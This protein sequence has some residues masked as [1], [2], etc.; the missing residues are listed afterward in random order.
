MSRPHEDYST[1]RAPLHAGLRISITSGGDKK[2]KSK[3]RKS[4][5][6]DGD[7]V[8][9]LW[10]FLRNGKAPSW[11]DALVGMP[12]TPHTPRPISLPETGKSLSHQ[13]WRDT[14]DEVKGLFYHLALKERGAVYSIALRLRPDVEAKAR[15]QGVAALNWLRDRAA[16][17][18]EA[19][20]GRPVA[21]WLTLEE[22]SGVLH[23]HGEIGVGPDEQD[24]ARLALRK[25][26]G[27]WRGPGASH[28]LRGK[29]NPDIRS[30]GYA[31]K[32]V[33]RARP[34]WRAMMKGFG[35][36]RSMTVTFEGRALTVTRD[37]GAEA[38]ALYSMVIDVLAASPSR[39]P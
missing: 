14:G 11:L 5:T 29:W 13:A 30:A 23:L 4:I 7:F 33:H 37:V 17:H 8:Q 28:Q 26:G 39:L 19:A 31:L 10:T 32:E 25:A 24:A 36:P 9:Q 16:Y 38:A 15:S 2:V 22:A 20:L 21:F 35:S 12:L 6:R 1:A 18:L 34:G 3:P 27:L